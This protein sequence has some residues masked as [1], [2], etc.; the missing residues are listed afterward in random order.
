[1]NASPQIPLCSQ[2]QALVE[3][4]RSQRELIN[5]QLEA[6][7]RINRDFPRSLTV[8]FLLHDPDRSAQAITELTTMLLGDRLRKTSR[9]LIILL[10]T[11]RMLGRKIHPIAREAPGFIH[12]DV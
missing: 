10:H 2:R 11:L 8:R 5:G 6:Q 3:Q 12:G 9:I 1:M 4:L 7:P